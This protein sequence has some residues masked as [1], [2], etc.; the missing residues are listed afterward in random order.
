MLLSKKFWMS[1]LAGCF[2]LTAMGQEP[3]EEEPVQEEPAQEEPVQEE[4]VQEEPVQQQPAEDPGMGAYDFD[5][6]NDRA[7]DRENLVNAEPIPYPYVREADVIWEKRIWQEIDVREKMNQ[8]FAHPRSSLINVL[9]SAIKAGELTAY[10]PNPTSE[11]DPGDEFREVLDPDQI[12]M[13]AGGGYDTIQVPDLND[14]NIL[15][16]TIIERTFEVGSV[17]KYRIKEDWIFDKQRSMMEPRIIG[18]AP[19]Y[20]KP[21]PTGDTVYVPMFWVYYP[22]ARLVLANAPVFNRFNQASRLT[23]DDVFI[24]RL[25]ASYVIKESNPQDLRIQDYAQGDDRMHESMRIKEGIFNY[26]HDLWEY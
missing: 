24:Q 10:D 9:L 12:T 26:E 16:D 20:S 7:Y 2:A 18:L 1:C 17:Q 6:P 4:P 19:L 22:E 25:F 13:G 3:G 23:Y 15:R 5:R 14:P 21:L 11:D 8:P